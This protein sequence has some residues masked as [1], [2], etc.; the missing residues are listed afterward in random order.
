YSPMGVLNYLV[1]FGWSH[2]D[3]EIFS[4]EDLVAK[5]DFENVGKADGKFDPKKFADVAF[6]HLKRPDLT[7]ASGYARMVRPFLAAIGIADPDE[8]K[9]TLAIGT[10]RERA[11]TLKEA[12]DAMSY[13]FRDPDFDEK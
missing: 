6:E 2:G 12:A 1:R 10:I 9:L 11:R 4:K 8:T 5:F 7:P 3:E 13:Y